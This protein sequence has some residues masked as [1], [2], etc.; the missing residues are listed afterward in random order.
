MEPGGASSYPRR[1]DSSS[2]PIES[3]RATAK[4]IYY[5]AYDAQLQTSIWAVSV[6]GGQPRLLVTF[7][8]PTRRSLRR[9]FATDGRRF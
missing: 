5:K 2:R 7:D 8:D 6:D 4:T 3:G 1:L 9:E